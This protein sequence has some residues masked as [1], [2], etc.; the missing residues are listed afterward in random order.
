M[1]PASAQDARSRLSTL[2]KYEE[3]FLLFFLS[4]TLALSWK[5]NTLISYIQAIAKRG[6][7][8]NLG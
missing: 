4:F 1:Q 3:P 6:N 5:D 2:A 8:W 7:R